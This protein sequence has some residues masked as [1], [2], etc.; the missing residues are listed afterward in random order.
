MTLVTTNKRLKKKNQSWVNYHLNKRRGKN[1][2]QQNT[3]CV[4]G[5]RSECALAH[6]L[7]LSGR[8]QRW[9]WMPFLSHNEVQMPC[10][11]ADVAVRL[12]PPLHKVTGLQ[13]RCDAPRDNRSDKRCKYRTEQQGQ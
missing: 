9:I 3:S 6:T 2:T 10:C 5:V 8:L 11:A 1:K 7:T 12:F 13:I 4:P